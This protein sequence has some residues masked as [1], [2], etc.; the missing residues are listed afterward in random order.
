MNTNVWL[1]N[2]DTKDARTDASGHLVFSH[3]PGRRVTAIG[4][5]AESVGDAFQIVTSAN[6]AWARQ[7]WTKPAWI[8]SNNKPLEAA[9]A[10][11]FG[12]PAGA[13]LDIDQWFGG[14]MVPRT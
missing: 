1:G 3:L 14:Q 10:L 4:I 7:S 5:P 11:F 13:P 2:V 12:C 9:F 6:G 8:V